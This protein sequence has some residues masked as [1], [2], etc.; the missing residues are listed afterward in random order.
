MPRLWLHRTGYRS[1]E[2]YFCFLDFRGDFGVV[3]GCLGNIMV[4]FGILGSS[5]VLGL[6]C[7]VLFGWVFGLNLADSGV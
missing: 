7:M 6:V 5:W 1:F 3:W 2:T 4:C